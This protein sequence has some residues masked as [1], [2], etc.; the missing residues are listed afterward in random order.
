MALLLAAASVAAKEAKYVFYFIGDGMGINQV[1][2]TELYAAEM[3]GRIGVKP[4]LF[5]TFPYSGMA[6]T[7]S[8]THG[9]TD[10]AASGSALSGGVKT[11]NGCISVMADKKTPMHGIAYRAKEAGRNVGIATSVAINHATPAAFYGHNAGRKNYNA[12]GRELPASGFDFFGGA[13]FWGVTPQDSL[14]LYD[15][16]RKSGYTISRSYDEYLANRDSGDRHILF[17]KEEK[18]AIDSRTTPYAIDAD[19]TDLSMTQIVSAAIDALTRN[20]NG[21]FLM[22]EGGAIDWQC[23]SDDAAS[24]IHEVLAFDKAIGVAYDFYLKHPDET[25]IVVTADH[26]TGG[27]GLGVGPYDLNLKALSNQKIS[28]VQLARKLN[29]AHKANGGSLGWDEAKQILKDSFGLF[30]PVPVGKGQEQDLKNALAASYGESSSLKESEYQKVVPLATLA[31]EIIDRHAMVS[32]AHG[33]HSAA[34]VPVYAVGVGAEK[35]SHRSD[36]AL[37]PRIIARIAGYPFD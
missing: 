10:S 37:L 8:V 32:W 25:L 18:S 30:G 27:L 26:E 19:S 22:M 20:D 29:A 31:K 16:A 13:D 7:Y 4:L 14:G 5:T 28:E 35:F 33:G 17:Q 21:F 3:E 1:Q 23:H 15:L 9:V 34:M 11:A 36:N 12:I 24:V 6:T 2:I